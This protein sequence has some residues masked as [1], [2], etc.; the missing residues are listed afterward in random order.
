MISVDL[1][2]M[3][4]VV[5]DVIHSV[6]KQTITRY[7]INF[8]SLATRQVDNGGVQG[9][10]EIGPVVWKRGIDKHTKDTNTVL[11]MDLEKVK[12][13]PKDQVFFM[14]ALILVGYHVQDED[15]TG[16]NQIPF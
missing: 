10:E 3:E 8:Q 5:N 16:S 2:K 4:E 15:P 6:T 11:F 12:T 14:Y 1:I 9:I 13:I 7:Y